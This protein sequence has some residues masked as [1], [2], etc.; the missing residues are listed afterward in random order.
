M[1]KKIRTLLECEPIPPGDS[2]YKNG[3]F[4]RYFSVDVTEPIIGRPGELFEELEEI[5][6]GRAIIHRIIRVVDGKDII[7][8]QKGHRV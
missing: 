8:M 3:E 5:H 6:D 4:V 1:P 7:I 2:Y